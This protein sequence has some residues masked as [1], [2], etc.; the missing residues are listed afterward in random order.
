[1]G[2]R[3]RRA[4]WVW[5]GLLSAVPAT[6]CLASAYSDFNTGVALRESDLCER[7]V[8]FFSSAIAE[9]DLLADLRPVAFLAR[10]Q[11]YSQLKKA[12]LALADFNQAIALRPDYYDAFLARGM[13]YARK[14][15]YDN[16]VSDVGAAIRI[17]PDLPKGYNGMAYLHMREKKYDDVVADFTKLVS[18]DIDLP[19]AYYFRANAYIRKGDLDAAMDDADKLVSIDRK[20]TLGFVMRG[21]I[22]QHQGRFS[23][24]VDAFDDALELQQTNIQALFGKGVAQW[25]DG[26]FAKAD[27]TLT[28]L[29]PYS[30]KDAYPL[31]WLDIARFSNGKPDADLAKEA[32]TIDLK[33]WPGP[34]VS[35]YLG[36]STP[37]AASQA[38]QEGEATDRDGRVCEAHFY[39]AEWQL[40]HQAKDAALTLLNQAVQDCPR[41]NVER[42]AATVELK[43]LKT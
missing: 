39:I 28:A 34:L 42:D 13:E 40:Q 20:W 38:A 8:P 32:Q 18:L 27:T 4:A 6:S 7:A 24:A 16:A 26:D 41:E 2:D 1:M 15:A 37:E 10:G 11:C 14:D 35:L 33:A 3:T 36:Q 17:R 19:E 5:I 29:A 30:P 21:R 23:R 12:D 31:L 9:P 43:R 25:S 22:Y